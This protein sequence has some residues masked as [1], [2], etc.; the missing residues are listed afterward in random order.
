MWATS[1]PGKTMQRT[2]AQ[3]LEYWGGGGLGA[4]LGTRE[5]L[6]ITAAPLL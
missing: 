1:E 6:T 5:L 3:M 4:G 2:H